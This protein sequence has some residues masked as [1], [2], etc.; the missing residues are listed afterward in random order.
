MD[1]LTHS[2]SRPSLTDWSIGLASL[3]VAISLCVGIPIATAHLR[4]GVAVTEVMTLVARG[5]TVAAQRALDAAIEEPRGFILSSF[6]SVDSVGKFESTS[7]VR[8]AFD[9]LSLVQNGEFEKASSRVALLIEDPEVRQKYSEE[10]IKQLSQSLS[11]ASSLT[12]TISESRRA[13]SAIQPKIDELI[14]HYGRTR[15][16]LA[17]FF[18]LPSPIAVSTESLRFYEAGVLEELPV[19]ENLPAVIASLRELKL[20]LEQIGG[21]V[22]IP[23]SAPDSQVY[24]AEKITALRTE[25]RL[26][27]TKLQAIAKERDDLARQTKTNLLQL[28]ATKG[29]VVSSVKYLFS[30]MFSMS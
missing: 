14:S 28:E 4:R 16:S 2:T 15:E 13:A 5:D 6:L 19:L 25:S 7:R 9:L 20:V 27:H 26:V 12:T 17:S 24:F 1:L 8:D 23:A 10:K 21:R 30:V 18:S 22:A 3:V 11:V 29:E